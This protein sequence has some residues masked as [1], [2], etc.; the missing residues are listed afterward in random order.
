MGTG[1][2][3][4]KEYWWEREWWHV[5]DLSLV[6]KFIIICPEED[7]SDIAPSWGSQMPC[8]DPNWSL[9]QIIGHLARFSSED[10]DPF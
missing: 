7:F 2:D 4:F 3:Y 9:E 5:G 1:E 6:M 8:I 10:I